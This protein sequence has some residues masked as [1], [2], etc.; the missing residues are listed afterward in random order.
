[1]YRKTKKYRMLQ[2]RTNKIE[3]HFV[4]AFLEKNVMDMTDRELDLC[5]G[6]KVLCHAELEEYF[7]EI[8]KILVHESIAKWRNDEKIYLPVVGLLGNY[9]KI[10]TND[11]ITTKICKIANDFVN[12]VKKSNHG[13][14]EE[15]LNKLFGCLGINMREFDSTWIATLNTFGSSRGVIAHTSAVAQNPI[16]ISETIR[17]VELIVTGVEAFE[18]EVERQT[19]INLYIAEKSY[20]Q[21]IP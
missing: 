5:R 3:K 9:E 19:K 1:M 4:K 17:E 6:Y 18:K 12:Y 11:T 8:A 7:E 13:I 2:Q 14:K 21:D 10:E 15:N 16:N 20:L